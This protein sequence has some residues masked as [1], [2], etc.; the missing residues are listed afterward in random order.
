[1]ESV[2]STINMQKMGLR[3]CHFKNA[4]KL[5]DKI[6]VTTPNVVK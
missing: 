3:I 1:M 4:R 5:E 6:K 2:K